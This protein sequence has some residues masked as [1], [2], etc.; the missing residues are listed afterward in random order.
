MSI[1]YFFLKLKNSYYIHGILGTIFRIFRYPFIVLKMSR[2]RKV[3]FSSHNPRDIFISI[4]NNNWWGSSESFSGTGSTLAYTAKIR[5]ELPDLFKKFSIKT[6]YDAPCGDFN[7][8]K[9][10]LNSVD[11]NYI[12]ADIVPKL[13]EKNCTKYSTKKVEFRIKN[14]IEDRFPA[15]DLWIC[16]DCFIH[17]SFKDIFLTLE[18]F[19]S[20]DIPYLLTTTHINTK[21]FKNMDIKTGDVRV[22]DLFSY[23]FFLPRDCL[24]FIDDWEGKDHPKQLVLFS[25]HQIITALSKMKT[26]FRKSGN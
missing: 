16:R 20:S 17:F 19:A 18:N 1:E 21:G 2:A 25:Q 15:A 10:F 7:W 11:I 8:M 5:K 22:L 6:I 3:I 13:I 23:P 26:H 24:Y 12:G 14:I 4:Y 9:I